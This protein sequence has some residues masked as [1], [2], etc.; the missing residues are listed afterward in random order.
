MAGSMSLGSL[1]LSLFNRDLLEL[2]Q[3]CREIG[4]D[5]ERRLQQDEQATPI[6]NLQI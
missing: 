3:Q 1:E 6:L 5:T 4:L 2:L